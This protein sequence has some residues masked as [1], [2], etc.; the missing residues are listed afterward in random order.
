MKKLLIAIALATAGCTSIAPITSAPLMQTTVDEKALILSLQTFDTV[1][2]AVDQL[3]AAGVIKPGSRRAV[4][5]ADVI[6]KAKVAFNAA[7]AA[8]RA[9]N[10]TNYISAI[11]DAQ[12]A[13]ANINILIKG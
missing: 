11:A 2:T 10:A 4:Q 1:L 8:Q 3:I 9:G 12:Q 5:I 7:S 13:V 6:A